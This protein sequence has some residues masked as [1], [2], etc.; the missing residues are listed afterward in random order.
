MK[1]PTPTSFR[2]R[3][4]TTTSGFTI[5]CGAAL[6]AFLHVSDCRAAIIVNGSPNVEG[7][8]EV[9]E[10]INGYGS[11]S[12][13]TIQFILPST[14]LEPLEQSNLTGMA[15]RLDN[16]YDPELPAFGYNSMTITIGYFPGNTLQGLT[17]FDA[18]NAA[19]TGLVTVFEGPFFYAAGSF[20]NDADDLT[21]NEFG[22]FIKFSSSFDYS[23]PGNLLITI[24]H[25][26][27]VLPDGTPFNSENYYSADAEQMES[28]VVVSGSMTDPEG[29]NWDYTPVVAFTNNAQLPENAV[30]PEPSAALLGAFGLLGACLRRRRP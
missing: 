26:E 19:T 29:Y 27:P 23:T 13:N 7:T 15:F 25:S 1:S 4:W 17:D 21:P 10:A 2:C 11:V 12:G 22:S 16:S 24:R 14:V 18:N 3:T 9:G 30:I 5:L 20:P 8:G 28:P 6:S